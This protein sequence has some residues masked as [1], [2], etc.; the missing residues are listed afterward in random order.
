MTGIDLTEKYVQVAAALS[1]RAGLAELARFCHGSTADLPFSDGSFDRACML[2]VGMNVEDLVRRPAD[3]AVKIA[4]LAGN[5]ERA[6][7]API[8]MICPAP[9]RSRRV[10]AADLSAP[11]RPAA[12]STGQAKRQTL[13]H[14]AGWGVVGTPQ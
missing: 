11:R 3:A 7:L 9:P 8:E 6:V 5:L 1:R 12:P 13:V 2:H 4:N 10:P 14:G